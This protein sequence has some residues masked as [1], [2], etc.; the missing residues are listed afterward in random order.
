MTT[1]N[2]K[3]PAADVSRRAFLQQAAALGTTTC[4]AL[5]LAR[6]AHAAGSGAIKVGMIGS[7]GRATGAA[8]N[9]M[10]AGKDVH[11][12]AMADVF[13][14]RIAAARL[15]LKTKYPDQFLVDE[16]HAF[17]GFD[18]YQ[19]VLDSG[20]DAVVIA[21]TSHFHPVFLKAAIDAGKHVF[22]EKPVAVDPVGV[23]IAMAASDDA[24]K[25]NLS[26]VSGF[27]WRYDDGVRETIRRVR[28]GAIG[29][30]LTVQATRLGGPYVV[31]ARQAEWSEM[32]YQF[33]NWYH[34]TWLSGSDPVQNLVHQIDNASWVL[35]DVAPDA[36]WGLGGRQ[37][38][39]D[40][41]Q[42]GDELDHH[43]IVYEYADG[44]RLFAHGRHIPGCFNQAAVIANGTKGRA[45][46][47]AKPYIEGEKPWRF[48][49]PKDASSMT[50]N[51][52]KVLFQAIRDGKPVNDGR[53]MC[54]SSMLAILG[55]M[56]CCTGQRTTWEQVLKSEFSFALPSYGWDVEPPIKPGP[57]G[58]YPA[59]L[60][61][62]TKLG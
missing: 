53:T 16:A 4:G 9:A 57:D 59:F 27:C 41:N 60:P 44:K 42:F 1:N 33:Q 23:R 28:D 37:V 47:P 46:M 25:K 56:V 31:R 21:C 18:A 52:H 36:A 61:G 8:A 2:R 32:Q 13:A 49:A 12:V 14:E 62:I 10:N 22:I 54:H 11:V 6:S 19:K 51:E 20:V 58:H 24:R 55:E 15:Q 43:A 29:D 40:P 5:A 50:D 48:E 26:V 3:A 34:F 45:Y 7:G 30:V 39:T 35:D 17:V 38:C